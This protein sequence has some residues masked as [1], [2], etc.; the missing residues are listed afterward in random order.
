MLGDEHAGEPTGSKGND[1]EQDDREEQRHPGNAYAADAEQQSY[2]GNECNKDDQ[3]IGGY[4]DQGVRR[5]ALCEVAPYKYHCSAG[6]GSEQHRPRKVLTCQ[7]PWNECLIDHVEEEHGDCVHCKG[8]DEPVGHPG[9]HQAPGILSHLLDA[10]KVDLEHHRIDHEPDEDG[11]RYGDVCILKAR[12][13]LGYLG[14][15]DPD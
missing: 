9:Y 4:L 8:L 5:I 2:D 13:E 3:V 11:Y 7:I 14:Q 10:V 15:I 12:E 1:H 6:C